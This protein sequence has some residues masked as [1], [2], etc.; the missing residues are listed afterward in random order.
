MLM[1]AVITLSCKEP[2]CLA[3]AHGRW[4]SAWLLDAVRRVD[5][6]LAK[7]LHAD[8]GDGR[9][10]PFHVTHLRDAG[11]GA[12]ARGDIPRGAT[13]TVRIG[14]TGERVAEG[15]CRAVTLGQPG[16]IGQIVIQPI[17]LAIL[18]SEHPGAVHTPAAAM[19]RYWNDV[20]DVPRRV[21]LTFLSPTAFRSNGQDILF[22]LPSLVFGGLARRWGVTG[23]EFCAEAPAIG[24]P[25]LDS[26]LVERVKT[27]TLVTDHEMRTELID[28]R[29]SLAP[30][31]AMRRKD[32][33]N[34]RVQRGFFGR[35]T[36]E[37]RPDKSTARVAHLLADFAYFTGIGIK[38]AVGM[39]EIAPP[40]RPSPQ[41][42]MP[43]GRPG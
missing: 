21:E 43:T 29:R 6:A 37:L 40:L 14:A 17:G 24:A 28:Y 12:I 2:G 39:G 5:P 26:A 32:G 38:T 31:Q 19:M 23:S 15:I 18:P 4:V 33:G 13:L 20:G 36:F 41:R 10:K 3:P 16:R 11:S 25:P 30:Q 9:G 27:E 8:S 1:S 34:G 42:R 7:A 22:P 35:C